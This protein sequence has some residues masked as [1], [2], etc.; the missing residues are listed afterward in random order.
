MAAD[1]IRLSLPVSAV[2][3]G[4]TCT[5]LQFHPEKSGDVG[6]SYPKEFRGAQMIIYPAI[7]I[8]GGQMRTPAKRRDA[9]A[10]WNTAN[11]LKWRKEWQDAGREIPAYRRFGRGFCRQSFPILRR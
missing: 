8:K 2:M 3:K 6:L 7:D 11:P 4:N 1:G 10:R 9:T 5:G